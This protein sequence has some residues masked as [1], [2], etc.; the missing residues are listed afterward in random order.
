[1]FSLRLLLFLLHLQ[2]GPK[3]NTK[4]PSLTVTVSDDVVQGRSSGIRMP[5][6]YHVRTKVNHFNP[7]KL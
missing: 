7:R 6:L 1:M 3:W 4:P 2:A 5:K